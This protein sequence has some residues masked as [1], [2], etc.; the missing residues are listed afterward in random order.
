[1]LGHHVCWPTTF[2]YGCQRAW[3][4]KTAYN[5]RNNTM[6]DSKL[7]CNGCH[8]FTSH[9]IIYYFDFYLHWILIVSHFFIKKLQDMTDGSERSRTTINTCKFSLIVLRMFKIQFLLFNGI[10]CWWFFTVNEECKN[11][12]FCAFVLSRTK[13]DVVN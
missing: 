7:L 11:H 8:W 4:T 5:T 1:M 3:S 9:I 13:S 12:L 2:V 10:C 6:I